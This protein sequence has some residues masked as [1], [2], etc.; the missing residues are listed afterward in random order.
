MKNPNPN[1]RAGKRASQPVKSTPSRIEKRPSLTKKRKALIGLLER[2]PTKKHLWQHV[3]IKKMFPPDGRPPRYTDPAEL[4]KDAYEYF[5][6]CDETPIEQHDVRG[7]EAVDVYVKHTRPYSI[8]GM[9]VFLCVSTIWWTEFKKSKVYTDTHGFPI[10]FQLIE[11]IVR[12][13][14]FDGA[15]VGMFNANIISRD[16]GL[17]DKVEKDVSDNRKTIAEL[18]P[19]SL[20]RK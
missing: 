3:D 13:Q 6:W 8:H 10:V 14:K 20:K 4:L 5:K 2:N 17:I 19:P 11:D 7:K 16:L 1:P 9:C 15:A 12:T 18:F